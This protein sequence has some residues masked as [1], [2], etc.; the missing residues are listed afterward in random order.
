M[1]LAVNCRQ[2]KRDS[3]ITQQVLNRQ[4]GSPKSSEFQKNISRGNNS[5][6]RLI[7]FVN[8]PKCTIFQP[9]KQKTGHFYV[10]ASS[11]DRKQQ[12]ELSKREKCLVPVFTI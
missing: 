4:I 12:T 8:V 3:C 9:Q 10:W 2:I 1:P 6:R 7:F 5:L 11:A